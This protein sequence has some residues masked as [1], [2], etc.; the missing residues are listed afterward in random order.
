MISTKHQDIADN[1]RTALQPAFNTDLPGFIWFPSQKERFGYFQQVMGVQR[2][3]STWLS[4]FPLAKQL[5]N[6]GPTA[7]QATFVDI[8]GG[9]GH[10]CQAFKAAVPKA[11]YR[12][13]LQELPQTLEHVPSLEGIETQAHNFFEPQPVHGM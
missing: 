2:S 3:S 8:G 10:Q 11:D 4:A 9:F 1:A 7:D 6:W 5:E 13:I 12:I